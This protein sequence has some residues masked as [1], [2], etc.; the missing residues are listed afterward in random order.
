MNTQPETTYRV[1]GCGQ[2]EWYDGG[3]FF[4]NRPGFHSTLAAAEADYNEL[5]ADPTY[6]SAFLVEVRHEDWRVLNEF[7][8]EG[9]SLVYGPLGN[10]KVEKAPELVLV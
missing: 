4:F 6:D 10:F 8:T 2:G 1:I 3:A 9:L 7:G 5:Y